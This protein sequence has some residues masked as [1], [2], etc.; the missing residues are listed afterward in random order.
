MS[1]AVYGRNRNQ[2]LNSNMA[3]VW[4]NSI[5]CHP[6]ATCNTA[7]CCH[8]VSSLSWSQATCHIAGCKYSIRN[9]EHIFAFCFFKML[10]GLWRAAAFVSSPIHLFLY[11]Y[12]CRFFVFF[13]EF[14]F[15]N[16]VTRWSSLFL[17]CV[18]LLAFIFWKL[19]IKPPLTTASAA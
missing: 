19:I 10:F 1:T 14:I 8:L 18:Q 9:I 12:N 4:A 3:D 5:A 16:G 17:I 13:E 6:R 2:M 11:A 7:G 15:D